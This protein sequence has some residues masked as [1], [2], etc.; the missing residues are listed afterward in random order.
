[1]L[2]KLK[3]LAI[4]IFAFSFVSCRSQGWTQ[5]SPEKSP[6]ASGQGAVA[7]IDSSNTAILFGGITVDRWLNETWIW[8]QKTWY[9]VST[10]HSP[11][12]RAKLAMEYDKAR[13]K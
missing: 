13:D 5:I 12:A 2:K 8:N 6:P 3:F 4:I 7:L 10:M 1:M 9:Q 11:P